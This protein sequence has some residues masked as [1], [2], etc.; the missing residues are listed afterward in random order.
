VEVEEEA[1]DHLTSSWRS[2]LRRHATS[3]GDRFEKMEEYARFGICFYWLVD[4]QQLT[5]EN[6]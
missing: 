4:P 2:C 5:L 3:D 6:V 1:P